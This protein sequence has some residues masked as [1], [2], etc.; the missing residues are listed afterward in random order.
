MNSTKLAVPKDGLAGLTENFKFD[1]IA[2]FL[3]F[4][5]AL[6]LSLG[7]AKAGEFPPAMG[8]LTAM[9]GGMFVGLFAGSPLTIKG[10]A[11]GLITIVAGCVTE[12]GGGVGGWHLA[13]GVMVVAGALQVVI[14]FLKAGSLSDFFP[15]SAVHGMLAAIGLII[16]A[17]QFHILL[18]IDPATL[19]GMKPVALYAHIPH[20]IMNPNW[21]VAVIG[22]IS[23]VILFGLPQIKNP[24]LK[25]IPAPMVVLLLAIPAALILDFKSTQP[26]HILVEIGDFW[27]TVGFNSDFSA[28]GTF[29][30]WKYVFMFL[31]VGS[32][33]SCLTVK[34]IDGLDPWKRQSNFNKDLVA[35]GAGN[36]LAAVLGG[37]P[38]ISEVARSSA[39]VNFG[40]RTRWANFFHGALLFVAMLLMIP[41]IE[42]IPNA[43]LAAMLIF[44]GYRL[45]SPREF[46]KTY[47]IGS[48]QLTIFLV[49]IAMT[50]ATD[51]LVGIAS[52]IVVKFIFHIVNGVSLS[53]IFKA[54]Y[55][56]KENGN[57]SYLSVQGSAI[58]SNLI[59]FKNAF[60]RFKP[61]KEVVIDF[62]QAKL[63][64]HT[65]MEFLQHF[66]EQ[67]TEAGGVVTVTGFE[68]FEPFSNHPLA[69]RK[70]KGP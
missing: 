5:L 10:S 32:L 8:V 55:Q 66:E 36:T 42:M 29:V 4:L 13:L 51:L 57:Q 19:A 52:G 9:I 65:F 20:S 31:I 45:A 40:A 58:F 39:N 37:S 7:I 3:V 50:V 34:A 26:A 56:L 28:I 22:I 24:L 47:K 14:G 33:E 69:G 63:V 30:F 23:L 61:G 6:P 70:V 18:G 68:R 16:I 17:K 2:G 48:E 41:V 64:D 38:M 35:V 49:T 46:F 21:S 11:A 53:N 25:K 15:L 62:S 12:L 60:H 59:G 54:R 27:A 67:F 44:V 1:F 43:A